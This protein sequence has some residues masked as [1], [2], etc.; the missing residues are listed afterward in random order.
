MRPPFLCK[1][2]KG[3][4]IDAD[5]NKGFVDTFNWMVDFINNL[6]GDGDLDNGKSI[7]LD[8][9]IDDR[10]VIRGGGGSSRLAEP[11]DYVVEASEDTPSRYVKGGEFWFDGELHVVTADLPIT[12]S[13]SETAYLVCE[14]TAR[15]DANNQPILDGA[16]NPIYDW[17]FSTS[18]TAGTATA[19]NKVLNVKLYDFEDGVIDM[20]Y[21]GQNLP[22]SSGSPLVSALEDNGTF[23]PVY[24]DSTGNLSGFR[25]CYWMNGGVTVAMGNQSFAIQNGVVALRAGAT[26][27]TSGSA[28]LVSYADIAALQAAQKDVA[29]FIVPLYIVESAQIAVDLRRI[30]HI[31]TSEVL[32]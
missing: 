6:R 8:R 31:Y 28:S 24:N 7:R 18:L 19:P 26:P 13:G 10:P 1:L 9:T 12:G 30:P 5:D 22:V 15:R 2:K 14:G 23:A 21:R 25:N 3:K 4:V 32:P 17:G 11:F 16:G 27:A 29:Y 20:D